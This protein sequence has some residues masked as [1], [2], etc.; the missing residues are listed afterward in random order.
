MESGRRV[1]FWL[2]SS[3]NTWTTAQGSYCATGTSFE[4]G[5]KFRQLR[6]GTDSRLSQN[7]NFTR[8]GQRMLQKLGG[9]LINAEEEGQKRVARELHDNVGQNLALI[10]SL[11]TQTA[12]KPVS[13][14][15]K[16]ELREISEKALHLATEIAE[17]SHRLH[18]SRLR[19]L[20]LSRSLQ[21]L[22]REIMSVHNLEIEWVG[23]ELS[24]PLPD[25]V[26]LCL[27]RIA[28]EALGNIVTHSKAS[29]SS[30]RLSEEQHMISLTIKDDGI[31]FVADAQSLGLGL[32]SM[33]KRVRFVAG[34][35]EI[36]SERRHGTEVWVL[37]PLER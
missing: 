3:G 22:C 20:G 27:Y 15:L 16:Q 34:S 33:R 36:R 24:A 26:R 31:G 4:H 9:R 13:S 25:E 7:E 12:S 35:I 21:A 2:P 32:L 17:L 11:S 28:Q 14:E 29:P 8:T 18:P 37:V 19:Y 23:A 30:V 1:N 5:C 6:T 10:A